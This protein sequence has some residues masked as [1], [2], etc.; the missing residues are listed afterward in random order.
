MQLM[1]RSL[2]ISTKQERYNNATFLAKAKIEEVMGKV[3]DNFSTNRSESA[4]AFA[5]P[6]TDYKYTVSDDVGTD[7]K[8]I[9]VTAWY[10]DDGDGALDSGE[11]SITLDTKVADR[12]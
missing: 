3:I 10:D 6:Y 12:S 4:T 5:S 2:D 7:I 8:V 1:A 9:S 11:E